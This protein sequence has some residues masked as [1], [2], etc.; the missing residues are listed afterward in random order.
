LPA[1][2]GSHRFRFAARGSSAIDYQNK[3]IKMIVT[4]GGKRS[5]QCGAILAQRMS[6]SMGQA[7]V[8]NQ[9]GAAGHRR[10]ERVARANRWLHDQS[11]SDAS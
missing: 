7:I 6:T 2:P 9:P 11:F 1:S 5:G 10:R 4:G 3:P 8:E